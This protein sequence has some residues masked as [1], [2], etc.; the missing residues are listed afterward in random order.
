MSERGILGSAVPIP[1]EE[2][3]NVNR[4]QKFLNCL[5]TIFGKFGYGI[6]L[7]S[8]ASIIL[9]NVSNGNLTPKVNDIVL[10][11]EKRPRRCWRIGIIFRLLFGRDSETRA[12]EVASAG[13][14]LRRPIQLI[15]PLEV[16][17]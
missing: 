4:P 13:K 5:V 15:S 2:T 9:I 16:Y 11:H 10:L 14:T 7:L 17:E 12:A 3:L 1:V 8:Y 6:I